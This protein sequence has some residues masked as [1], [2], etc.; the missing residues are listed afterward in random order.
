MTKD[1]IEFLNTKKDTI[2]RYLV[3][4]KYNIW[5]PERQNEKYIDE[6]IFIESEYTFGKITNAYDVRNN[7]LLEFDTYDPY[8]WRKIG[9][10]EYRLLGDIQLEE[11]NID[12]PGTEEEDDTI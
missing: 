10:K 3:Y 4:N 12:N 1:F 8:D 11:F 2:F 6:T 7:I 5:T 9:R